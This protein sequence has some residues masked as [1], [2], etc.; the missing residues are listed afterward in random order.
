MDEIVTLFTD[1][2]SLNVERAR[3]LLSVSIYVSVSVCLSVS[4]YVCVSMSACVCVYAAPGS[5]PLDVEARP[6]S[7]STVVVQW[8]EPAIPNGIIQVPLLH[9]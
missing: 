3:Q 1:R 9:L 5:A 2:S 8:K 4:V 6:L 7:S